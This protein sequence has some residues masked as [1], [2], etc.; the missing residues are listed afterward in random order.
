MSDDF[1]YADTR[2]AMMLAGGLHRKTLEEGISLR[3]LGR[4]LGYKQAVVLSHMASG[5]MPIPIDRVPDLAR[6]VGLRERDFLKA[7]LEQRHPDIEW[8]QL[9]TASDREGLAATELIQNI[10][11]LAQRPVNE[12]FPGQTKVMREAAADPMA[13][14]RWLSV[15]EVSAIEL[16]RELRPDIANNGLSGSDRAAIRTALRRSADKPN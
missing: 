16:L 13:A 15:H 9:Q 8:G 5:R 2:A 3:A 7:V 11:M 10:E 14:R 12:L 6:V 4:Q 1:E